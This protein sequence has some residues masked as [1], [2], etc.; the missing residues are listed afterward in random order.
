[1]KQFV[2]NFPFDQCIILPA[3]KCPGMY[4]VTL[5]CKQRLHGLWSTQ[6]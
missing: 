6:L 3:K 5:L 2:K 4:E 1:M